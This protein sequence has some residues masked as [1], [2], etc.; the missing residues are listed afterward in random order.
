MSV[1]VTSTTDTP[2]AVTAALGDLAEKVIDP[3]EDKKSASAEKADETAD[4]SDASEEQD[5]TETDDVE[6]PKKKGGFQRRID[7]LNSKASLAERERDYWREQALKGQRP[8]PVVENAKPNLSGKPKQDDFESHDDYV[9]ALTD[10]KVENKLSARDAKVKET[11]VKTEHQKLV[12]TFLERKATFQKDHADYDELMEDVEDIP[13]SITVREILLSSE[14]GPELAYELA[15][16]KEELKRIAA[17]PAIACAREIGK[18][19]SRLAKAEPIEKTKTT[20]APAPI[21]PVKSN[22][23]GGGKKSL[24]DPNLTQREYEALRDEQDARKRA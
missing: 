4:E 11:E 23:G 8:E 14:N 1:Q 22:A 18:F 7:K 6:K 24:D 2:E 13:L 9:E 15:K 10:W 19:E 3:V 21:K 16:N 12:D 5:E 17:L 20:K